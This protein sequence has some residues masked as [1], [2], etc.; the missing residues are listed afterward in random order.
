V[1]SSSA[2]WSHEGGGGGYSQLISLRSVV[3]ATEVLGYVLEFEFTPVPAVPLLTGP[4][5]MKRAGDVVLFGS[6]GGPVENPPKVTPELFPGVPLFAFQVCAAAVIA[7]FSA[8]EKLL[9]WSKTT[10]TLAPGAHFDE[11]FPGPYGGGVTQSS[12]N[13]AG[14]FVQMKVR[15][16][17]HA[18]IKNGLKNRWYGRVCIIKI[19]S[20]VGPQRGCYES[21]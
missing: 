14:T 5:V 9:F 11:V 4:R 7:R 3:V 10:V 15:I 1:L 13:K 6:G 19:K 2:E 21:L 17:K 16:P 12:T 20:K 18:T 8:S